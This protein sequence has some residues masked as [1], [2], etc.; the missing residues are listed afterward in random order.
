MLPN[1]AD[2]ASAG[3]PMCWPGLLVDALT[4]SASTAVK[5]MHSLATKSA[6]KPIHLLAGLSAVKPMDLF[7]PLLMG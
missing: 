5:P 3:K 6:V 1:F 7:A 2:E 4:H